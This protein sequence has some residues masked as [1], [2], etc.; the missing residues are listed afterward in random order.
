MLTCAACAA[1][2]AGQDAD[3]DA[4]LPGEDILAGAV[5]ALSYDINIREYVEGLRVETTA[6][7]VVK[8]A[9]T[10]L[11]LDYDLTTPPKA[12]LATGEHACRR[13]APQHIQC[14]LERQVQP[15]ERVKLRLRHEVPWADKGEYADNVALFRTGSNW[16]TMH[17]PNRAHSWL[18]LHD[19]PSDGALFKVAVTAPASKT[20]L[21]NGEL[22]SKLSSSD[23]VTWSY[24]MATPMPSYGLFVGVTDKLQ[25]HKF[26]GGAGGVDIEVWAS[27]TRSASLVTR[28][29]G[30]MPRSMAFLKGKFGAYRFGRTMRFIETSLGGWDGGMEHPGAVAMSPSTFDDPDEARRTAMHEMAH[31]WSGNSVRIS[32]WNDFWMSEAFTEYLAHRV[33]EELDGS[34][35]ALAYWRRTYQTAQ[36]ETQLHPL[37]VRT[38]ADADPTPATVFSSIFDGVPYSK[39]SV[40]VR[41]MEQ[42]MTRA[43]FDLW[44]RGWFDKQ[45]LKSADTD[46]LRAA[47]ESATRDSWASF[48]QRYVD[49]KELPPL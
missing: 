37:R 41:A 2:Q 14:P 49:G 47:M 7:F 48:F 19:H 32:S 1:S 33:V 20:V 29:F 24:E 22:K 43:K 42:R 17:W 30:D 45:A 18:A 15:G 26:A 16:A 5:D 10:E 21:A 6:D 31:H 28:I 38:Q 27:A 35:A 4:L 40:T 3:D 23:G 13:D 11:P 9:L 36:Q 8:K 44:L 25:V 39:G 12:L 34:E 46:T